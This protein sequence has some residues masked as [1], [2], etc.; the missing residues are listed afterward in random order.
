MILVGPDE[1]AVRMTGQ[2][3]VGQL[4]AALREARTTELSD[5]S[6]TAALPRA[7]EV[8]SL[9]NEVCNE[10]SASKATA[11]QFARDLC[12]S[13]VLDDSEQAHICST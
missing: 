6:K 7:V 10:E 3:Q 13:N 11:H 5:V 1:M 2:P 8:V 12:F 9:L 4:L